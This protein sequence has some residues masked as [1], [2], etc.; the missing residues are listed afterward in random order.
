MTISNCGK[1][2]FRAKY[3]ANPGSLLGRLWRWHANWCPGW[4]SYLKALPEAEKAAIAERYGF[5]K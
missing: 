1:C 2:R 4:K 3:D 5:K